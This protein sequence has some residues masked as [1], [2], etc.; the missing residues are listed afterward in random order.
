M[1]T[2]PDSKRLIYY[3]QRAD[4]PPEGI[5]LVA[6]DVIQNLRS[7][8]DQ[9]AYQLFIGNSGVTA[10]ARHVYFP[11]GRDRAD[12]EDR[13]PRDTRG[14]TASAKAL[15]DSVHP[16]KGG[17]DTLWQ[18]HELNNTD[19]HRTLITAG[20]A[21][22]SMDLGA[23]I[24]ALFKESFPERDIPTMSAFFKPADILFPLTAG[25]EL[26]RDGP[27]AKPVPNMQFRFDIVLNELGVIEGK[28]LLDTLQAMI[29]AV[30]AVAPIFEAE[31]V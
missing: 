2:D 27:G 15:I 24:T 18:L 19:K 8:L 10:S 31:L 21:F 20:S 14:L 17:N 30:T 1:K 22:Q 6:G 9:L 23:H 26:F 29:E 11:I 5:A 7:S 3:V 16:Y 4:N 12:Y 28:P 13:K 25:R